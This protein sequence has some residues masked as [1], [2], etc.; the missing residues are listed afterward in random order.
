MKLKI[1]FYKTQF[2]SFDIK[3]L[4]PTFNFSKNVQG[5]F[6]IKNYTVILFRYAMT[7]TIIKTSDLFINRQIAHDFN[8]CKYIM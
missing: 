8:V 1:K 3:N 2:E 4:I 5:W 6:Y 7:I